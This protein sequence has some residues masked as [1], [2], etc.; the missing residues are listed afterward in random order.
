MRRDWAIELLFSLA[1]AAFC[2]A[3][4]H[5]LNAV[6]STSTRWITLYLLVLSLLGQGRLFEVFKSRIAR[7]LL[8]YI[9]WCVL[10]CAWSEVPVLSQLK[11]IA[12]LMTAT[13]FT[14]AGYSWARRQGRE[15]PVMHLVPVFVIAIVSALPGP[16][17]F[18]PGTNLYQGL[19]V[20]PNSLGILLAS[21]LPVP[22]YKGFILWHGRVWSLMMCA[23]SLLAV[24][25]VATIWL[26]A[27]RASA[28]CAV[29]VI[30][31]FA[32]CQ[33]P[34]R[35]I[36]VAMLGILVVVPVLIAVPRVRAD[37]YERYAQKVDEHGDVFFTRRD[38]WGESYSAALEGG[39]WGVGYG[40]SSGYTDF[41]LG[42][43]A[44]EYGREKGNSQLG[45]WEETGIVGLVLYAC[46]IFALVIVIHSSLQHATTAQMKAQV[47]LIGGLCVGLLVQSVFEAWWGAPGSQ[48][49]VV[50]F[51]ALGV[52]TGLST[53]KL[54]VPVRGAG[55][56]HLALWQRRT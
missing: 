11:S 19:T 38:S 14:V 56:G 3:D 22:M 55:V 40:V 53:T 8:I 54:L 42:L 47:A 28:L 10:T 51:A 17:K 30:G 15:D 24:V 13:T 4:V 45:V 5:Y 37:M 32:L 16:Q 7:I 49:F 9:A 34:S 2:A 23:W 20:N 39:I 1:L 50:F 35:R 52:L 18:N 26:T 36:T 27:S 41:N 33:S 29:A 6:F 31:S 43:T 12:L 25:M 21:G 46:L 48:E 44:K